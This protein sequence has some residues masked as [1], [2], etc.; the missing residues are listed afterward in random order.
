LIGC[1][2]CSAR[3]ERERENQLDKLADPVGFPVTSLYSPIVDDDDG[4][5]A[6]HSS[7]PAKV[8]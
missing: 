6:A 5:G 3:E 8:V 2:K 4:K 1:A 7:T